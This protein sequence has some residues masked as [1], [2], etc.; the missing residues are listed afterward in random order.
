MEADGRQQWI[1]AGLKKRPLGENVDVFNKHFA[2]AYIDATNAK[3]VP[4]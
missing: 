2:E 1:M 3:H 4:L